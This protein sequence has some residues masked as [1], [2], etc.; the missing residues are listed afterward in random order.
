LYFDIGLGYVG[1]TEKN[2]V[3]AIKNPS[4]KSDVWGFLEF[5]A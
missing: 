4:I 2:K 5:K 3:K 1:E